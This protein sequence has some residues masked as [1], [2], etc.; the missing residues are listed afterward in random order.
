MI[1]ETTRT[2]T[3]P[4]IYEWNGRRSK[5][6]PTQ[7]KLVDAL[8]AAHPVPVPNEEL[9]VAIWGQSDPWRITSLKNLVCSV[10]LRTRGK[11]VHHKLNYGYVL[12]K[13]DNVYPDWMRGKLHVNTIR[14]H[15]IWRDAVI[16]LTRREVELLTTL[17]YAPQMLQQCAAIVFGHI[18]STIECNNISFVARRLRAKLPDAVVRTERGNWHWLNCK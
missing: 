15:A 1:A 8:T 12:N 2:T 14:G 4:R 9:A 10:N 7:A 6:T 17:D 16:E 11:V 18:P 5:L 3:P 13:T